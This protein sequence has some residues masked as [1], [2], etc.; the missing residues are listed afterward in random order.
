MLCLPHDR[1]DVSQREVN[2]IDVASQ[3][4]DITSDALWASFGGQGLLKRMPHAAG[5][6]LA[7]PNQTRK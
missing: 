2:V 6:V 4:A 7:V 1:D 3:V 5:L